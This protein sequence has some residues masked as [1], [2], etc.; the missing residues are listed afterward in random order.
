MRDAAL[1][2]VAQGWA[3]SPC[4]WQGDRAKSPLTPH[5]HLDASRDPDV[6]RSWWARWPDAMI[7]APVPAPFVVLDVDPRNG[8]ELAELEALAGPLSETL[9]V[10]SGRG[11]GGRHWY[12]LRP[13]G[14]LTSTRLP[15]G[16]DLKAAGYCIMPP[17]LHPATGGPYR[18]EHR[19]AAPLP[20]GLRELLRPRAARPVPPAGK[21][22]D[23]RPLVEFVAKQSLGNINDALYWAARR[24]AETGVLDDIAVE[25]VAAAGHAAG[26]D[27]TAAGERQSWRTVESARR[28]ALGV[29]A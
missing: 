10:W 24:A 18:W 19:P 17:S 4:H 2:L 8:G 14:R 3:V 25:L 20:G 15:A 16:I 27:A 12:F 26:A 22:G 13:A 9:T 11:D 1:D 28:A 6:V 29:V 21:V 5:G 23:G 7:G